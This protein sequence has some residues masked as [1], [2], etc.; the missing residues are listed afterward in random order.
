MADRD[1]LLLLCARSKQVCD[2]MA[3]I[4]KTTTSVHGKKI[5][6]VNLMLVANMA[7]EK[8]V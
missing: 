1:S 7:C 6:K 3:N 2:N 4:L 5:R 8:D